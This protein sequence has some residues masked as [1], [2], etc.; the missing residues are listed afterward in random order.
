MLNGKYVLIFDYDGTIVRNRWP[1][2]GPFRIGA[3][4]WIKWF[5]KQ[6]HYLILNTCRTCLNK[7]PCL[8]CLAKHQLEKAGLKFDYYNENHPDLI[9][10]YGVDSRKISGDWY[11]DD[12]AGF[13]GWWTVPFI[14]IWLKIKNHRRG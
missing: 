7:H 10:Q 12:L 14:L 4:F 9:R 5:K 6:G 13:M 3:R 11:F 8:L 2:P 1:E